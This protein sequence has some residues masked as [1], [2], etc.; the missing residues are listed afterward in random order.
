MISQV[1]Y[2]DTGVMCKEVKSMVLCNGRKKVET[3]QARYLPVDH[4]LGVEIFAAFHAVRI[5]IHG[6]CFI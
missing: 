6:Q 1:F 5:R 4:I 2:C 3:F